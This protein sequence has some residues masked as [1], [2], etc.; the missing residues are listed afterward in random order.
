[1]LNMIIW[2]FS[3]AAILLVLYY[4]GY[5]LISIV[6][7]SFKSSASKQSPQ[8]V[9]KPPVPLE[10]PPAATTHH[11]KISMPYFIFSIIIALS[12]C[13]IIYQEWQIQTLSK[14]IQRIESTSTQFDLEYKIDS[15]ESELSDLDS[16]I[17]TCESNIDDL[18]NYGYEVGR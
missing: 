1:M 2:I 7:K 16:R 5:L 6:R 4:L 3:I 12:F 8:I 10:E 13:F 11:I 9:A 17:D 15:L 18:K 14:K